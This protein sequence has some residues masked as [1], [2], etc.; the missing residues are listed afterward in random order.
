VSEHLP[1]K[2]KILSLNPNTAKTKENKT[3]QKTPQNRTKCSGKTCY[4]SYPGDGDQEDYILRGIQIK[5]L[6]EI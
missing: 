5:I 4:P 2:C 3:K 1:S 6:S